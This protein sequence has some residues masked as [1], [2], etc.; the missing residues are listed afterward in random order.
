MR[1]VIF[2]SILILSGFLIIP[3][4]IT[5]SHFNPGNDC[6]V[7]RALFKQII[8]Q[9]MELNYIDNLH[10]GLTNYQQVFSSMR[11]K[12][13]QLSIPGGKTI[14]EYAFCPETKTPFLTSG[15]SNGTDFMVCC[16]FHQNVS[17]SGEI[18]VT[19]VFPPVNENEIQKN[20]AQ[21]HEKYLKRK[22]PFGLGRSYNYLIIFILV[23]LILLKFRLK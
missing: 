10:I 2:V 13:E 22:Y 16:Q 21:Y 23:C 7:H 3:N 11:E 20:R 14:D 1:T 19:P 18:S 5:T 12:Q 4:L 6:K 8:K 15:L 9:Y 17:Y